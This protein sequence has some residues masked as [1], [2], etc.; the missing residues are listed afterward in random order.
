MVIFRCVISISGPG[1]DIIVIISVLQHQKQD[2]LM[3][4]VVE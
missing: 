3:A 2:L 1:G 4:I